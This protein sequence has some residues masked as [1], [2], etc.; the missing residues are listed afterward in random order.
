LYFVGA[1]PEATAYWMAAIDDPGLPSEERRDLIEDLNEHGLLDPRHPTM[2]DL[3]LI[4][5]RIVLIEA[6]A[7]Y[8]MDQV[9]VDAFAEAHKDLVGL[10]NGRAPQ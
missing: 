10:L 1:D 4:E 6:I 8:S 9:N 2:A 5:N 3:P 7:P